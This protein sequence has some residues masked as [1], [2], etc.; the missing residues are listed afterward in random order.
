MRPLSEVDG[1]AEN[2][3]MPSKSYEDH[4]IDAMYQ[5]SP[6]ANHPLS[7]L[8]VFSGNILGKAGALPN[9]RVREYN[10]NMKEKF[11]RDVTYTIDWI[12]HGD[13]EE[14]ASVAGAYDDDAASTFGGSQEA[15]ERS[16]ACLA[17]AMEGAR[18][19]V[20]KVGVL[21]SFGYVASA[22]CLREVEKMLD[23][24]RTTRFAY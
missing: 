1:H 5:F 13:P 19:T 24:F 17:V 18:R 6:S 11:N 14:A 20:R 23:G 3:N 8:E 16:I 9:K 7:E 12:L 10:M 2:A 22:V 4:L 21:K 15:L